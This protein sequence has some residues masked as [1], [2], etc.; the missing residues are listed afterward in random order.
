MVSFQIVA[1]KTPLTASAA[2]AKARQNTAAPR[3]GANPRSTMA[4]PQTA[5][6]MT[7]AAPC[8]STLEVQD[9]KST[10]LNSSHG[11]ISYAVFCLKKKKKKISKN[12]QANKHTPTSQH[13]IPNFIRNR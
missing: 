8:R 13:K 3:V 6:A 2:P 5:A 9:R 10:R 12:A 7:T 4:R 11:Y 1:R